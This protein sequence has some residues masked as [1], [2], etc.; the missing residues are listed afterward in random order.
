[1]KLAE[2]M[3]T[4]DLDDEAMAKLIGDVSASAVKK[5][6]YGERDRPRAETMLRIQE[7]T[8]GQVALSDWFPA[9]EAVEPA[10]GAAA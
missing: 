9:P 1:M 8:A 7:V 4:H 2:Y 6:R 3:K 10:T 5:W